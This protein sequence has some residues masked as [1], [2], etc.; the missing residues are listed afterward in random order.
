LLQ[1]ARGNP[2]LLCFD[3]H[4]NFFEKCFENLKFVSEFVVAKIAN[5]PNHIK[6]FDY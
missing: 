3:S 2:P 4:K 6:K 5:F 1:L